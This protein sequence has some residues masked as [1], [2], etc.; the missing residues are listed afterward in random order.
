MDRLER[1]IC[2]ER[3]KS[4]IDRFNIRVYMLIMRGEEILVSDEII[5]GEYYTKFPGGGLEYGEGILDCLHREALEEL[6]QAVVNPVHFYTTEFAQQSYFR[7]EDQVVSVYYHCGLS[8]ENELRTS[9]N[10][11]NFEGDQSESLRWVE[12]GALK[13]EDLNFPIDKHVLKLLKG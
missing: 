7:A 2:S 12:L 11:Y 3:P 5:R 6:G 13:D 8:R 1:G 4:V 10:K 9:L